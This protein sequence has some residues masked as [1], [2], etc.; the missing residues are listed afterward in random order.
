[1]KNKKCSNCFYFEEGTKTNIY[2][3]FEV[4]CCMRFPPQVFYNSYVQQNYSV[5][6]SVKKNYWC[7]EWREKHDK[8]E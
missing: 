3:K 8:N 5:Y 2:G 1:M 4:L 6:P 7:G